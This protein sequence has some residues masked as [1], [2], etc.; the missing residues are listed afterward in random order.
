MSW[1]QGPVRWLLLPSEWRE[2]KR[3]E[4][5]AKAV[6][7]IE[8]FWRLRDSDPT[9][10]LNEFRAEFASRVEA[11]DLLYN[12]RDTR[13]SLSD[14]GRALILLGPPPHMR[15]GSEETLAWKPGRRLSQRSTL[16]E[17]RVEIWRY[18]EEEL[19]AKLVGVLRAAGLEPTVELK[20]TLGRR[21]AQL[22]SGGN[23]LIIVSRLALIRD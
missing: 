10:E 14:R 20:F 23:S 13:G 18:P 7:F 21:G 5:P 1:A 11:A 3:I 16:R 2:L 12:E 22:A 9:T 17:I 4:N 15:I 6:N 19:P 8:S